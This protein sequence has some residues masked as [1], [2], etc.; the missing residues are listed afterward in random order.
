MPDPRSLAH[1]VFLSNMC[2]FQTVMINSQDVKGEHIEMNM[3]I[4]NNAEPVKG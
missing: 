3:H 4:S 2:G 1:G